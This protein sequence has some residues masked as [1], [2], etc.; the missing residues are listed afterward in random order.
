MK[1]LYRM[2]D[3]DNEKRGNRDKD[4]TQS[5]TMNEWNEHEHV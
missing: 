4:K 3:D 2:L 1:Y 5:K